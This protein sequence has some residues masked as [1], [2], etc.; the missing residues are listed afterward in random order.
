MF[1]SNNSILTLVSCH[2]RI[3]FMKASFVTI[4]S[5]RTSNLSSRLYK[6]CMSFFKGYQN[7]KSKRKMNKM[8]QLNLTKKAK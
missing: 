4:V 5:R 1:A 7:S 8:I 2:P 6:T 3:N